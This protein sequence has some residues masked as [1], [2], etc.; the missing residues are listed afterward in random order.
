MEQEEPLEL[1][2][3]EKLRGW[4][5]D[6]SE[7]LAKHTGLRL[8]PFGHRMQNVGNVNCPRVGVDIPIGNLFYP[9]CGDDT[10][11]PIELFGDCVESCVF[12]DPRQDGEL[13]YVRGGQQRKGIGAI[14]V[15]KQ[16]RLRPPRRRTQNAVEFIKD[17]VLCFL[18]DVRALS[19]FFYRGDSTGEGG[20]DQHWL[21]PVLFNAV[22]SRL[23]PG[24]LIVTDGSNCGYLDD[25]YWGE[26]V[27]W[28]AMAGIKPCESPSVGARF[29]HCGWSF[30]CVS[31]PYRGGHGGRNTYVWQ[32]R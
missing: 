16:S 5:E 8:P 21:G 19:V 13:V 10:S 31:G 4:Y 12:A 7:E 2:P 27:P 22:L 9:C 30:E 28:N 24:G 29:E 17:G 3:P 20:S 11:L 25:Y 6:A 1:V 18:A 15:I 14:R 26:Y 32:A 23:Q